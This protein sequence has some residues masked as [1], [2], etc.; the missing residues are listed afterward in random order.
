M[1]PFALALAFLIVA[2]ALKPAFIRAKQNVRRARHTVLEMQ[3]RKMGL[4]A[5]IRTL[6]R[7]S[8]GQRLTAGKD[9]TESGE[10]HVRIATLQR[11]V[12]ELEKID[13]RV[14]VLDERRGLQETGWVVLVRR[15]AGDP[16]AS[17]PPLI[18][19]LWNEGRYFFFFASDGQKAKRK[20]QVRF[21]VDNGF[22][23][24]EA[25][26]QGPDLT[27]DPKIPKDSVAKESA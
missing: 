5:Q 3:R 18:T 11:R 9:E 26:P 12:T 10:L 20:A 16:P 27:E 15:D 2:L 7:E 4:S 19:R 23:V 14:L 22:E 25:Y 24:V 17:E 21:P 6:A 13:R 8:L 1:S